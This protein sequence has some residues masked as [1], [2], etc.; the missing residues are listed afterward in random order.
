MNKLTKEELSSQ[1]YRNDNLRKKYMELVHIYE[2]L[3]VVG[4]E[5]FN[6][7][8]SYE[9]KKLLTSTFIQLLKDKIKEYEILCDYCNKQMR[10]ISI[11]YNQT[12][13]QIL[14]DWDI[15]TNKFTLTG[16]KTKKDK[17]QSE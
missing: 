15:E 8:C 16:V 17:A 2:L 4:I 3:S 13:P 7:F 11:T 12:V 14:P 6:E 5:M 1:I 9:N 10:T